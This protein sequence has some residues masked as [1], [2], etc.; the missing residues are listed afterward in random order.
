MTGQASLAL[1]G[2]RLFA[3]CKK[4]SP[5]GPASTRRLPKSMI[6]Q[7]LPG[8]VP[9][10]GAQLL[11]APTRRS[12]APPATTSPA[13]GAGSWAW[14]LCSSSL[15]AVWLCATC[16]SSM[17]SRPAKPATP[18]AQQRG[19]HQSDGTGDA[20]ASGTSLALRQAPL[21]NPRSQGPPTKRGC[22]ARARPQV[23]YAKDA[24][25][26]DLTR[27]AVTARTKDTADSVLNRPNVNMDSLEMSRH[28]AHRIL[29]GSSPHRTTIDPSTR[30]F[31]LPAYSSARMR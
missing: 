29:T 16:G 24:Q 6:T 11:S 30:Q 13:A 15:P 22:W 5:S 4:R 19:C 2:T 17:P 26:A 14:P 27:T 25:R 8:G 20:G 1:Q 28:L 21:P 23:S 31:G 7:V 9:T 18:A 3:A 12:R 10:L